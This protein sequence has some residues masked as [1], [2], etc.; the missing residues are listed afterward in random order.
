MFPVLLSREDNSYFVF[1]YTFDIFICCVS[2]SSEDSQHFNFDSRS[3]NS[4]KR[5]GETG[6]SF[7][8]HL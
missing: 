2:K 6:E 5:G 8:R 7:I 4:M 1:L 3:R